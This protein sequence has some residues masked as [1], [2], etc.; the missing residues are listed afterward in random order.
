MKYISRL[1]ALL[2]A[3]MMVLPSV[4][5]AEMAVEDLTLDTLDALYAS[6]DVD[7]DAKE[8][9]AGVLGA[10]V[11][12]N[13]NWALFST[14]TWTN[15][16]TGETLEGDGR[17]LEVA[18]TM[19]AQS[20]KCTG[21]GFITGTQ[22][23]STTFVIPPAQTDDMGAYL[24]FLFSAQFQDAQGNPDRTK[25]Y[26][27]VTANWDV[28]LADGTNL[29]D[30]VVQAWMNEP[31]HTER[32]AHLLCTCVLGYVT[33]ETC[34]LHPD[35]SH[36]PDC[37]W[38]N[39]VEIIVP[40]EEMYITPYEGSLDEHQYTETISC[41][42]TFAENETVNLPEDGRTILTY[43]GTRAANRQWQVFA[44]EEW[45]DI[46]GE[47]AANIT[48]TNAMLDSIFELT[49]VV[50]LR[51]IDKGSNVVLASASVVMSQPAQDG[52]PLALM[53]QERD[54]E[55]AELSTGSVVVQYLYVDEA[56][57]LDGQTVRNP[58]TWTVPG[59]TGL[60]TSVTIPK[61]MGYDAYLPET[62]S[63]AIDPA[64][65][66]ISV[67]PQYA[68]ANDPTS[69]ITGLKIDTDNVV[70]VVTITI[71]YR[72]G[73]VSFTVQR[74]IEKLVQGST[75]AT[76]EYEEY[77]DSNLQTV[78]TGT[79][80][81][82]VGGQDS[83]VNGSTVYER[84]ELIAPSIA[85]FRRAVYDASQPIAA[86][87]STV[88]KV[89]YDRMYYLVSIN[90]DGGYGAKPVYAKYGTTVK[91]DT[92]EKHGY[93]FLGWQ[94]VNADGTNYIIPE[95]GLEAGL[96][97]SLTAYVVPDQNV[98][99]KA[100]WEE[101]TT[102]TLTIV[103]WGENPNDENYSV[104]QVVTAGAE[105]SKEGETITYPSNSLV[106]CGH[107]AHQHDA[108]CGTGV[109]DCKH[110]HVIECYSTGSN[111]AP[112]WTQYDGVPDRGNNTLY[113]LDGATYY[114]SGNYCYI[115]INSNDTWYYVNY[116][117]T[118][119]NY[120]PS[121]STNS[122]HPNHDVNCYDYSCGLWQ[123]EH[124]Q[125]CYTYKIDSN[126]WTHVS[127]TGDSVAVKPDDTSV[128]NV[129]F[130]RV[131]YTL[132][133]RDANDRNTLKT[134][135]EK[136]GSDI[137]H[138]WPITGT[139][140][141]TYDDGQS[142]EVDE[143]DSQSF[144]TGRL[145]T[146]LSIMPRGDMRLLLHNG[147]SY[148][149]YMHYWLEVLDDT[150]GEKNYN[151][152]AFVE[153]FSVT[154]KYGTVTRL[155]DFFNLE[156]YS[157]WASDPEFDND[158]SISYTDTGRT[159]QVD[160]Y[161]TRNS[162]LLE[163]YN[164]DHE[165]TDKRETVK[166]EAP[167]ASY[168]FDPPYPDN[169]PKIDGKQGEEAEAYKFVGWYMDQTFQQ[170]V[171][172]DSLTMP[173][174][175]V[176]N[177]TA[178]VLYAKWEP[179]Q[180]K[181]RYFNSSDDI[182]KYEAGVA[183]YG[184]DYDPTGDKIPDEIESLQGE[185]YYS[186]YNA[187]KAQYV[188]GYDPENGTYGVPSEMVAYNTRATK[189]PTFKIGSG[190][191]VGWFY[192]DANGAQVAFDFSIPITEDLDLYT[193]Y[194]QDKLV[195]YVLGYILAQIDPATKEPVKDANG[196]PMPA[197]DAAGN[198][199]RVAEDMVLRGMVGTLH[200]HDAKYGEELND[201]YKSGYFPWVNSH[202]ITLE[203]EPENNSWYNYVLPNATEATSL[204]AY[205]FL[206]VPIQ[207][208]NY[209][210][211]YLTEEKLD[212]QLG[213]VTIGEKTYYR[214]AEDK[215]VTKYDTY[216]VTENYRYFTNYMPNA[217]QQSL[218][219][220]ANESS[221]VIDFIYTHNVTNAIVRVE[222]Y[223]KDPNGTEYNLYQT[224]EDL[225]AVRNVA[226]TTEILT[227][228][229]YNNQKIGYEFAYA[230]ATVPQVDTNG[231]TVVDKDGVAV[232][233]DPVQLREDVAVNVKDEQ[234]N[235]VPTTQ[236]DLTN[237]KVNYMIGPN[238]SSLV[239]KLY[240]DPIVYPYEIH[241]LERV[242]NADGTTTT[243]ELFRPIKDVTAPFGQVIEGKVET[244]DGYKFDSIE[245]DGYTQT[246]NKMTIAISPVEILDDDGTSTGKTTP[247][248]IMNI[249]YTANT[250]TF[251]YVAVQYPLADCGTVA[252]NKDTATFG[253]SQLEQMGVLDTTNA[254]GA[255][256]QTK[257]AHFEFY[258][259]YPS[260]KAVEGD[261][262][263]LNSGR[264]IQLLPADN[265]A[266]LDPNTLYV[267]IAADGTLVPVK[268][269]PYQVYAPGTEGADA[270][271]MVTVPGYPVPADGTGTWNL[272]ARF[273]Y[274]TYTLK[275]VKAG[276]NADESAIFTVTAVSALD[277]TNDDNTE[278]TQEYWFALTGS[279][280]S[281]SSSSFGH[282]IAGTEFTIEEHEEWSWTYN[283]AVS[284]TMAIGTGK[285]KDITIVN[286]KITG[287]LPAEKPQ[288]P[289]DQIVTITI[290]NKKSTSAQWL[291]DEG[292]ITNHML[293]D[294]VKKDEGGD[295]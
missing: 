28:T 38:F 291:H 37:P 73:T 102:A 272:Y 18:Y 52:Q 181:V 289:A 72:R 95:T 158:D 113:T 281:S 260:A 88:V 128:L 134:I 174:G 147:S 118:S 64:G 253:R 131:E 163:F 160:F 257:N 225:D 177:D 180:F 278:K 236:I 89:Y 39:G 220:A 20:Y 221:N 178:L 121:V 19:Q 280:S 209:V 293:A 244:I 66:Q 192:T 263:S 239:L 56:S 151:G 196:N 168:K 27:F 222:H 235:N 271:G 207:P 116:R 86:D 11:K 186:A 250:V 123:H 215:K 57:K 74:L 26:D 7:P 117:S 268:T 200:T 55:E 254:V 251:N 249:Y 31:A 48:L 167:L 105:V 199:L 97:S 91:V 261:Q 49:G 40:P 282:L 23:A 234:G 2:L 133:F 166:Y 22:Y 79:T 256:V 16:L 164:Y 68:T 122:C 94:P 60:H 54:G 24:D 219:L 35:D 32:D 67:T 47:T 53:I 17:T 152:K 143:D 159:G 62:G 30:N 145:I 82:A 70:G 231:N 127:G 25:V 50:Y 294:T 267:T 93:T 132:T 277:P 58:N 101:D 172:W 176:A 43:S 126:L 5:Q 198:Y 104:M 150:S 21:N 78:F 252:L 8:V 264:N 12:L 77:V 61:V 135:E 81:T 191:P 226:Y 241:Y 295:N 1:T 273:T 205:I 286:G 210:V 33:S 217:Y 290:T 46:D 175:P 10:T 229:A 212:N 120:K 71:P 96:V 44:G 109:L 211:R 203:S 119:N 157:Q 85:G 201:G 149:Y 185:E 59:G 279:S 41:E 144:E 137:S 193:V 80:E 138:Y 146:Y 3:I 108:S 230:T 171:D 245:V 183:K 266:T 15:V 190:T 106:V 6:V 173:V 45:A 115:H 141:T 202:S 232:M 240:Y 259:W 90:E 87:G 34:L 100:V 75:S 187:Y 51:Y 112:S 136:W 36:L 255:K 246:D 84:D 140:G 184:E 284:A 99:F 153:D 274:N 270:N 213:T 69:R 275:I 195:Y 169:L 248:N 238:D 63:F 29:C 98:Y 224:F 111:Y 42:L 227:E 208:V 182:S 216:I 243:K 247:K 197:R 14:Y 76:L 228:L 262:I 189:Q 13:A 292:M 110:E 154:A 65:A 288:T 218:I 283:N 83:Q 103:F 276:L 148:T 287:T 155:E 142:W 161:Y 188:L 139:N 269:V 214:L 9:E 156:G 242:Q 258:N 107:P 130:D 125:E 129:Y 194:E 165:L 223:I 4:V 265:T 204:Q 285:P 237:H 233:G 124:V 114:R 92:P 162:Y 179:K 170:P 206:Y